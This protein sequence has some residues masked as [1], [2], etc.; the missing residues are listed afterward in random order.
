MS[1]VFNKTTLGKLDYYIDWTDWLDAGA[2]IASTSWVITAD[3]RETTPALTAV[4]D[5]E[6]AGITKIV[7][8][9]GTPGVRY[10]LTNTIVD[11]TADAKQEARTIYVDVAKYLPTPTS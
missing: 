3:N 11:D 2:A 9:G 4:S 1:N 7:V 6:S 10:R 8:T 5:T